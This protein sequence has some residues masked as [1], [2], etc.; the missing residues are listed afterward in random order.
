[1]SAMNWEYEPKLAEDHHFYFSGKSTMTI[2]I[3]NEIPTEKLVELIYLVKK[4]AI[5]NNGLDYIQ[6]LTEIT[7]GKVVWVLDG[8]SDEERERLR[9][10]DKLTEDEIKEYDMHTILFPE[11]Y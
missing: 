9:L 6:K 1:M 3:A 8:I 7:S 10:E 5:E 4:A 2:G 11:E